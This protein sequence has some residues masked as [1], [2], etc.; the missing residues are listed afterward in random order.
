MIINN[1]PTPKIK[2]KKIA[3]CAKDFTCKDPNFAVRF[4]EWIHWMKLLGAEKIYFSY[5]YLHPKI[6]TAVEY[7]EKHG[8]VEAWPFHEP[9][10]IKN[11]PRTG[12]QWWLIE[13]NI[14]N[15]CFYRVRNLYEYVVILDF[16]EVLMPLNANDYNWNDI[17]K[18]VNGSAYDTLRNMVYLVAKNETG[19]DGIPENLYTLR[20]FQYYTLLR[21]PGKS[22]FKTENQLIVNNHL[23]VACLGKNC[24]VL[25]VPPNESKV[26]HYRDDVSDRENSESKKLKELYKFKDVLIKKFS[27][28][29][30]ALKLR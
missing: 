3:V 21:G 24:E 26:F 22:I 6:F 27:K 29:L 17:I 30:K 18:R 12:K 2:R 13:E 16:D 15:D 9:S 7:F 20:N 5:K 1:Q 23:S 14:L 8:V 25:I 10:G 28:T 4:I 19:A 11:E